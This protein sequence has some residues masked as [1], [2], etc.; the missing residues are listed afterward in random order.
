M[1]VFMLIYTVGISTGRSELVGIYSTIQ[2]T[3]KAKKMDMHN[4][5]HIVRHE[6][7]Y[8]IKEIEIDT[9]VNYTYLQW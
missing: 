2:K 1:K 9:A 5:K 7:H 3:E 8:S 6:W 4:P